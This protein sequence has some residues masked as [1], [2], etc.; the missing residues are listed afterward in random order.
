MSSAIRVLR[1]RP[2][3]SGFGCAC[4]TRHAGSRLVT[5]MKPSDA[6]CCVRSCR[7]AR[8]R[9]FA[10]VRA[11]NLIGKRARAAPCCARC[12]HR[13]ALTKR[14]SHEAA[15]RPCAQQ[16]SACAGPRR[17]AA[18][19]VPILK[20]LPEAAPAARTARVCWRTS[21]RVLEPASLSTWRMSQRTTTGCARR[22][23]RAHCPDACLCR[24]GWRVARRRDPERPPMDLTSS[25]EPRPA[26]G[27]SPAAA[28]GAFAG[29]RGS[30]T[31]VGVRR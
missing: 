17:R 24:G 31:G 29:A 7:P 23:T 2:W 4:L 11:E 30:A 5:H 25:T 18:H 3:V 10:R 22:R 15:P 26:S 28:D 27:G 13:A 6:R 20:Y 14:A 21:G 1:V 16:H 9:Q 19:R 12:S 8:L